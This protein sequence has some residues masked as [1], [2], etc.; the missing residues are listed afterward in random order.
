[1]GPGDRSHRDRRLDRG[2][3]DVDADSRH[4]QIRQGRE[5][6]LEMV[7]EWVGTYSNRIREQLMRLGSSVD[8]T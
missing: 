3:E 4:H 2:R 1:M 8:W 7:Y 6:F 5:K